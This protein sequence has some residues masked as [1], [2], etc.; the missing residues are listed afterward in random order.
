MSAEDSKKYCFGLIDLRCGIRIIAILN[1]C[2]WLL[3]ITLN[4]FFLIVVFGTKVH[5]FFSGN[6]AE[7]STNNRTHTIYGLLSSSFTEVVLLYFNFCLKKSI[8]EK[9]VQNIKHWL[10]MY[11]MVFIH[12]LIYYS[13]AA[14]VSNQPL[15]LLCIGLIS[16]LIV[17]FMLYIVRRFYYDEL[18]HL[19]A[20]DNTTNGNIVTPPQ[21]T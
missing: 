21:S 20:D 5:S 9:N 19:A 12:M 16:S 11:L 8:Y 17:L 7:E 4:I 13:Y 10:V 18:G 2:V 14:L 15:F 1:I 3:A 6:E